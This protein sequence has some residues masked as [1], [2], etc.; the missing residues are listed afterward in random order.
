MSENGW[1]PSS[2]PP[3]RYEV[4]PRAEPPV[5]P[6]DETSLLVDALRDLRD[7]VREL[8]P[9]FREEMRGLR[10]DILWSQ[11]GM[12]LLILL[13]LAGMFGLRLAIDTPMGTFE[14]T[15]GVSSGP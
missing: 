9:E 5:R 15:P 11:M 13:F 10:K 7:S 4:L 3:S 2:R 6:P 12:F 8:G 14:A 1:S